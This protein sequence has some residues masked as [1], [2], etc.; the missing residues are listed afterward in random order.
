MGKNKD[1]LMRI[2]DRKGLF[3]I[4]KDNSENVITRLILKLYILK[5]LKEKMIVISF[6][7][8]DNVSARIMLG[9]KFENFEGLKKKINITMIRCSD[10]NIDFSDG[11]DNEQYSPG[12]LALNPNLTFTEFKKDQ[13]VERIDSRNEKLANFNKRLGEDPELRIKEENLE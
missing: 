7:R 6:G 3:G 4:L 10:D 2:A 11:S 5:I 12:N 9:D 1:S 8:G 13:K